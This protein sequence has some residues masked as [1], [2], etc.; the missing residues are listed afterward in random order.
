MKLMFVNDFYYI[1]HTYAYILHFNIFPFYSPVK[2]I[3]FT[4]SHHQ[5]TTKKIMKKIAG[6][7][8][9]DDQL[10][11]LRCSESQ[12][13]WSVHRIKWGNPSYIFNIPFVLYKVYLMYKKTKKSAFP[14]LGL[15]KK[16]R[17]WCWYS[18]SLW[19]GT[20]VTKQQKQKKI[21]HVHEL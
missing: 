13:T 4:N 6:E 18:Y 15:M 16:I 3:A 7:S 19:K 20:Q 8:S 11:L 21:Y 10:P 1:W 9:C 17:R 14:A 5:T 2:M 12:T